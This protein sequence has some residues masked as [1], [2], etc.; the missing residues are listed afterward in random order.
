MKE[1]IAYNK[2]GIRNVTFHYKGTEK[3]LIMLMKMILKGLYSFQSWNH[4]M[5]S[6][7]LL[8]SLD[9]FS[10]QSICCVQKQEAPVWRKR[11]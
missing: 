8:I 11:E 2:D 4:R 7:T 10:S 3:D 1:T 5:K 9:F 6:I